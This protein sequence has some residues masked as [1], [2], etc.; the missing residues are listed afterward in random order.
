MEVQKHYHD[1]LEQ[2]EQEAGAKAQQT[3]QN[4][5]DGGFID[6]DEAGEYVPGKALS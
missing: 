5:F 4:M 1:Q 6:V 3:L 2:R